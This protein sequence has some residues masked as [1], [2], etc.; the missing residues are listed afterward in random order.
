[1]VSGAVQ[2]F[3]HDLH[4]LSYPPIILQTLQQYEL[5]LLKFTNCHVFFL[6]YVEFEDFGDVL[7]NFLVGGKFD[8]HVDGDGEKVVEA[9][10]D[11]A[12]ADGV[13]DVGDGEHAHFGGCGVL[14]C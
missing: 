14:D 4:H 11:V 7:F 9:G 5:N 13:D 1:L 8:E 10:H 2:F 3:L 6:F 12:E